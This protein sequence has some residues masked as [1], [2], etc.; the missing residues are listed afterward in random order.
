M[1]RFWASV[2]ICVSIPVSLL[3]TCIVMRLMGYSMNVFTLIAL[4]MAVGLVVDNSVVSMDQIV[5]HMELGER[6]DAAAVLGASE[7]GGALV[8]STSTSVV[9]LIPLFFAGGM[10]GVFFSPLGAVMVSS[11]ICSFLV[12]VSF[13]PMLASKI[14]SVDEDNFF[15]HRCSE[16]LLRLLARMFRS[17]L[18]WS[19]D[20]EALVLMAAAL[21][22]AL[23]IIGARYIGSELS[24]MTDSGEIEIAYQMAEGTRVEETDALA[25][26]IMAWVQENVPEMLFV[27]A[28][29]GEDESGFGSIF[30]DSGSNVG[31]VS[32]KLVRKRD[33]NR[34]SFAVARDLRDMLAAKPAFQSVAVTVNSGMTPNSGKPFVIE[35]YGDETD[36]IL[37]SAERVGEM[38]GRI[39]G[40]FDVAVE[41]KPQSP[42][43]WVQPDR[44]KAAFMG[45]GTEQM[46]D[47]LRTL[48]Y[49]TE[50]TEKF[51]EGEDSYDIFIRMDADSK[52]DLGVLDRIALINGSGEP[53][54][55]SSIADVAHVRGPSEIFR[56]NRTRCVTVE[57]NISGRSLGEVRRDAQAGLDAM[58]FPS[59]ITLGWGGD[60]SDQDESFGNF[61]V[62]LAVALILCY[63]VMAAQYEAYSDPLIM[64][65]TVPFAFTGVVA[66]FLALDLYVSM[67][68]VLGMLMLTGVVVNHAIIY[69]DYV[70]LL[71][72]R[73]ALL[74]ESLLEAADRRLRPILMTVL[75]TC[76]GMLPLALSDGEGAEQWNAMAIC[77][78]SGLFVSMIV[79]LLLTPVA[80]HLVESR[81]RRHPRYAEALAA[82]DAGKSADF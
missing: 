56:K 15:V 22:M 64:M 7:V 2:V 42:E 79:T 50:T 23:S 16:R 9:V 38:L 1:K 37:D 5:Y 44:E 3:M 41:Q 24:P 48:F 82:R 30:G 53:V 14:R 75:S 35:V 54:R 18:A 59:A 57:A 19:L 65:L 8:G 21:L 51:W 25:R 69:L 74:R 43:I 71:R 31:A 26:D 81:L 67:Q 47:A 58:E 73:G 72:S 45:V 33:R 6:R 34:S 36:E 68:V 80:Y 28:E 40:A 63:M 29:D 61:G 76:L 62:L 32:I 10:V 11:L 46:A 12:A 17:T 49:G 70:N 27:Y 77:Y 20:R 78:I 4:A 52:R 60:V 39:P 66:V 13:V 55:M